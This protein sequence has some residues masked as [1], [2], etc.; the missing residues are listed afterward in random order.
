MHLRI[1][2]HEL[3]ASVYLP[4]EYIA[5]MALGLFS[6]VNY[7]SLN[8]RSVGYMPALHRRLRRLVLNLIIIFFYNYWPLRL[9]PVLQVVWSSIRSSRG[10]H[11]VRALYD[12]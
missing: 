7:A 6:S 1:R 2:L 4:P 9:F 5:Y 8:K 10:V 12:A 11:A 3:D